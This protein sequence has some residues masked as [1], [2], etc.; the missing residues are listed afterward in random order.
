MK[1]KNLVKQFYKLEWLITLIIFNIVIKI[2][3][4]ITH[5]NDKKLCA[6]LPSPPSSPLLLKDGDDPQPL[7]NDERSFSNG[8]TSPSVNVNIESI[9]LTDVADFFYSEITNLLNMD[10]S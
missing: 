5:V 9:S 10:G 8:I 2:L 1:Q 4:A 3:D 7:M 6:P